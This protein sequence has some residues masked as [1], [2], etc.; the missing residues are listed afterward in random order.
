M[1]TAPAMA[2]YT[3]NQTSLPRFTMLIIHLQAMH[4]LTNAATKPTTRGNVSMPAN[5][6]SPLAAFKTSSNA[7]PSMGGMTIRNENWARFSF[8]L[9]SSKPVA[10]V[11][12]ERE[13]PGST[14]AA[15]ARPMMKASFIEICSR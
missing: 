8:L 11:E 5:A 3:P 13:S 14:A 7:S 12:P 10:M 4:P 2:Q 1:V 6:S 9:P 15:W